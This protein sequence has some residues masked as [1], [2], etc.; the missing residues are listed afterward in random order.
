MLSIL[1]ADKDAERGLELLGNTWRFYQSRGH[2]VEAELWLQRFFELPDAE[3]DSVGLVKGVMARAA[4]HYWR[5]EPD[6]AVEDYEE[7]VERARELGD[8][9]VTVDAVYGLATSLIVAD[10]ADEAGPLLEEA[11]A[12]YTELGDLGGVADVVAGDA[13]AV[14]RESGFAGLA[15]AFERST[16]LYQRAGRQIQATQA[17]FAQTA[18]A[19][20]EDRLDDARVLARSGLA[21]GVDLSDVFLQTWGLQYAATIELMN[22]NVEVAALL[23]GAA[24]AERERIGGGW[25]PQTAGVYDA[26]TMLVERFDEERAEELIEPGRLMDLAEAVELA[27]TETND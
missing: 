5:E 25:G 26:K 9:K 17:L 1:H 21:R 13:F 8:Q 23:V 3:A 20:T 22:D 27:L 10:R 12:V 18:V 6:L 14:M 2:L 19:L 15:P 24:E 4:V 16:D 7:A 11:R